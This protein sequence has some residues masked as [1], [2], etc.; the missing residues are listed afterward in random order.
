[1]PERRGLRDKGARPPVR[2]LPFRGGYI[3]CFPTG[4]SSKLRQSQ[5]SMPIHSVVLEGQQPDPR[6]NTLRRS[7]FGMRQGEGR[8]MSTEESPLMRAPCLASMRF[9]GQQLDEEGCFGTAAGGSSETAI[10]RDHWP[11]ERDGECE[12]GAVID[13]MI[14]KPR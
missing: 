4:A 1:L 12:I 9:H 7:P 5:H 8:A 2:T 6:K 11:F 3:P 13:G 14:E 10:G